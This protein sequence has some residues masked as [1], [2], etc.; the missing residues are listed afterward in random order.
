MKIQSRIIYGNAV[1]NENVTNV[2]MF[3]DKPNEKLMEI[4]TP[5]LSESTETPN[6]VRYVSINKDDQVTE[7][8][9]ETFDSTMYNNNDAIF[10]SNVAS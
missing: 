8:T 1:G 5:L 6:L 2:F 3:F 9:T 7:S 4:L 10:D